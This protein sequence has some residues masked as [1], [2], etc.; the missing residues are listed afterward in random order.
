MSYSD[1][2]SL[3]IALA[4]FNLPLVNTANLFA[5]I[6]SIEPSNLLSESLMAGRSLLGNR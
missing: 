4:S 3:N 1:F 2:K 6:P 5:A